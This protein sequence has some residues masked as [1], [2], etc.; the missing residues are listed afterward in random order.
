[1]RDR[2]EELQQRAQEFS[3]A[4]TENT[5]PFP[6]EGD[7]DDSAVVGVITPQA[8]VFEEEPV[9]ENF[10]SEVQQI[11]DDITVL[12]TE[13]LKF[14]Q[15][16]KTLVA[17]MRRFSVM[18]KESSITRDIKL[19]AE[20]LHRRLDAL[21]KQVQ[22][23]EDQQGPTA[24]TTRIQR[25]Q[26]AALYRKFQQVMR[27]YNEGLLTKQECCKH[28]IIRQLEVS[29]RDV[30]EEEVNEMVA[31]GKW[32]VFNE[33]LLNDAK[34]TRSQLSEIEQRH[35]ELLSLENN[36]NELRDLFMDIF[37]LVEEQGAYIEHIQTSVERTQDYV[38]ASNEKFKM[39]ARYK[40]K[41]PLRQLCCCCCPPWRCC[42]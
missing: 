19:R 16:Q 36:M 25:S 4:A 26:Y 42:L 11:R 34:I 37:M 6:A 40:K 20:S 18:K 13:V 10:L 17:T 2:L 38:A 30:T 8:V 15:Q 24:V 23:T 39:A 5:N 9:V 33:N 12:D 41:N 21:S 31:T 7:N 35:K 28:F 27:Q 14:T 22:R 29:G 1:M 32:E 3:D